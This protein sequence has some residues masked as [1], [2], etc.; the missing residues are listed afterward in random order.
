MNLHS[1]LL[2]TRYLNLLSHSLVH[3][4]YRYIGQLS[5]HN[6]CAKLLTMEKV[7]YLGLKVYKWIHYDLVWGIRPDTG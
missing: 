2:S 1:G 6:A 3:W 5:Q 4:T 7:R